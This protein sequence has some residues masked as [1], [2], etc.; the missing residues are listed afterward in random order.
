MGTSHIPY[1]DIDT[2][3]VKYRIDIIAIHYVELV[4]AG[5]FIDIDAISN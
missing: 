1:G 3:P 5:P 2:V 4:P